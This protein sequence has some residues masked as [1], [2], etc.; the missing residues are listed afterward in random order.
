MGVSL[1]P[2][3]RYG[4][5]LAKC[6]EKLYRQFLEISLQVDPDY[7]S[8]QSMSIVAI[9]KLAGVSHATVSRVINGRNG[10]SDETAGHVQ[11][12]MRSVGFVP[13]D[14]R[15]GPKPNSRRPRR[16]SRISCLCNVIPVQMDRPAGFELFVRGVEAELAEH[17][18]TL[19]LVFTQDAASVPPAIRHDLPDGLLLHGAPPTGEAE[20]L[21]RGLP[22]VWLMANRVQPS[23]GD[24]V[25]PN[26]EAIG[27]LA[28]EY[29]V[30]RGH[31]RLAMLNIRHGWFYDIRANAFE[32]SAAALGASSEILTCKP[33]GEEHTDGDPS[34]RL[35]HLMERYL[36]LSPRPTGLFVVDEPQTLAFYSLLQR[37][38]IRPGKDVECIACNNENKEYLSALDPRPASID[39]RL[40]L[41]GRLAVNS[42][43]WR[44]D[45]HDVPGRIITEVDPL[46]VPGGL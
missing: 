15:P 45:H 16:K 4:R 26:S 32:S 21:Y 35:A 12:A 41:I 46:L 11:R 23:F 31:R 9:A 20:Q 6:I 40:E 13:S 28:A 42:L 30:G 37:H 14:R 3:L 36:A 5:K 2:G 33:Q 19:N 24:Q 22:V 43:L 1:V 29:L 17:A 38:G 18:M 25:M 7:R 10:V 27:Q 34:T 39:I 44:M 8:E